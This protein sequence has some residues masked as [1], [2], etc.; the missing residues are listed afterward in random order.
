MCKK[1]PIQ[2]KDF[3]NLTYTVATKVKADKKD[4]ELE[5]KS[6]TNLMINPISLD[7]LDK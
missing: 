2:K 5:K 6:S 3:I 7:R 1:S 4:K